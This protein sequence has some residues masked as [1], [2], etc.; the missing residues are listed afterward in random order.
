MGSIDRLRTIAAPTHYESE[1]ARLIALYEQLAVLAAGAGRAVAAPDA[2][3][4]VATGTDISAVF[5]ESLGDF[6]ETLCIVLTVDAQ[7]LR[8]D[9]CSR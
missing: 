8:A 3:L 9:L 6:S 7:T 2:A 1:H 5:T 4:L